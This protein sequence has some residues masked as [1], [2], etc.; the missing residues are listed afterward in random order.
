MDLAKEKGSR[1]WIWGKRLH[2]VRT[3]LVLLKSTSWIQSACPVKPGRQLLHEPRSPIFQL[4]T[5]S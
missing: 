2:A 3:F 4:A 1:V 5:I